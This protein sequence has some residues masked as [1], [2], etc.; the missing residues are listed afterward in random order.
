[1][2]YGRVRVPEDGDEFV[3]VDLRLDGAEGGVATL[4]CEGGAHYKARRK[5]TKEMGTCFRKAGTEGTGE[6]E[7]SPCTRHTS[8]WTCASANFRGCIVMGE[9]EGDEVEE[10]ESIA[11][12]MVA[13][14][15]FRWR[16]W[17]LPK[18]GPSGFDSSKR[19]RAALI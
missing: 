17:L 5:E 15:Q 12:T 7:D 19:L 2:K 13:I 11:C 6:R 18:R 1:M 10:G 14:V 4:V 16:W 9:G 8:S 3:R